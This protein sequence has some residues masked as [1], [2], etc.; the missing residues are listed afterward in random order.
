MAKKLMKGNEALAAAAIAAGAT[1]F[2]G[3]PITPQSELIEY[4]AREMPKAGRCFL[5]AES[6]VAASYMVYGA[7]GAGARVIVHIFTGS[8]IET[9][10]SDL[11]GS[12]SNSGSC[13]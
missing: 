3:Y 1:H 2:F 10:R 6:E 8:G 9:R 7:G 5:Q 13:H 4:M 11:Y 12:G